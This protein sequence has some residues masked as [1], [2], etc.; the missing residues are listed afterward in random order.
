MR[1]FLFADDHRR[2]A[3]AV[4]RGIQALRS[5]HQHRHGS[6]D[7]A[8]RIADALLDGLL[9]VDERRS[10]LGGVD[11]AAAHLLKMGGAGVKALLDQFLQI[12]DA[13]HRGDRVIAQMAAHDQRLRLRIGNTAD[14]HGALHLVHVVFKLRAE[15]RVF[16]I[17]NRTLEARLAVY[18]HAAAL[19]AQMRMIV[20]AKEQIEHAVRLR[21]NAKESA[22]CEHLLHVCP[23]GL[24]DKN[25]PAL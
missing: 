19:G 3:H 24:S 14:A 17:V 18:G 15:G 16:N 21:G 1:A 2:S 4:A 11:V 7:A 22:H 20:R 5:Q 12:V 9:A 6:V 10:Q 23:R 8:L 25:K 13:A